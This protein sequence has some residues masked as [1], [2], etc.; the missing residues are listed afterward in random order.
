MQNINKAIRQ[1]KI[2]NEQYN[3]IRITEVENNV[4]NKPSKGRHTINITEGGLLG[5]D[6]Q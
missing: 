1:Y 6:K 2:T 5:K 3:M 4:N